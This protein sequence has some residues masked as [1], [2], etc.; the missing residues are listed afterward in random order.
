MKRSSGDSLQTL[1]QTADRNLRWY[2][3]EQVD[4]ILRNVPLHDR[5]IVL[6]ADLLDQIT[7]SCT[8]FPRQHSPPV[9]RYPNQMQMYLKHCVPA[10][11]IFSHAPNLAHRTEYLLKPSPKGDGL[12]PPS[13][14]Q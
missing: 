1:N 2:R 6:T 8:H 12:D 10:M 7:D 5:H 11:S 9:L 13:I 14:G 4:V 3:H